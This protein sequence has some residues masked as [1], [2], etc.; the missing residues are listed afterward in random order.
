VPPSDPYMEGKDHLQQ[1]NRPARFFTPK[2]TSENYRVMNN[3]SDS[4]DR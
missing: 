3:L 4:A 1:R 2:A